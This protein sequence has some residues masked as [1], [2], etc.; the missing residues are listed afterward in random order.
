M[1]HL[2]IEEVRKSY[3]DFTLGPVTVSFG[4]GI[5][6]LLGANGA[7]KSTLMRIAVGILRPDSGHVTTSGDLREVAGGIGYLPQDFAGPKN[8]RLEDYLRFIA[9]SRSS[10]RQRIGDR[11]VVEAI[12]RV[13]L[14]DKSSARIGSLSGGMVRR[15][16]VAQALLGGTDVIV[17]DEPT[18]GLDP[19]QRQELR[20]LLTDLSGETT[21]LLSTHLSED[22]AA[23][24]AHVHVL[25]Q[26]RLEMT[27]SVSD[28]AA[29]G[30]ADSVSGDTVENGFLAVVGGVAA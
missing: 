25:H 6:A 11:E 1:T 27:G 2:E 28:L 10:R 13:G 23:I 14:T 29:R 21:I 24:A 5:T 15:L 26:G 12:A 22:V 18:V 4:T 3:K 30:G 19:V 9:W 16:G 20:Q 7:G 8:V 17:L